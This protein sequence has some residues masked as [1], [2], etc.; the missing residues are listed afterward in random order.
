MDKSMVVWFFYSDVFAFLK[1]LIDMQLAGVC[2]CMCVVLNSFLMSLSLALLKIPYCDYIV[3]FLIYDSLPS[4]T[5]L[6]Q[7]TVTH[8]HI[9]C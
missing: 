8:Y 9:I 4:F 7:V 1:L 5:C 3:M 6:I 2:V